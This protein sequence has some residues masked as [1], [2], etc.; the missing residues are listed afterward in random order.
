MLQHWGHLFPVCA[1]PHSVS[2]RT[3]TAVCFQQGGLYWPI[4]IGIQCDSGDDAIHSTAYFQSACQVVTELREKRDGA[5]VAVQ[6]ATNHFTTI[7][8]WVS[9]W[10]W[11]CCACITI[12]LYRNEMWRII[13]S[14]VRKVAVQSWNVLSLVYESDNTVCSIS[15]WGVFYFT[16]DSYR[17]LISLLRS[18][19]IAAV[20]S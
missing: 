5:I 9:W 8:F 16:G 3:L 20:R 1:V 4:A 15:K 2:L 19:W 17:C 10:F 14:P 13:V 7:N 12:C 11:C 18:C 6:K